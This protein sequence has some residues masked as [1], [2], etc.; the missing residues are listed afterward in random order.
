MSSMKRFFLILAVFLAS[1]ADDEG[2]LD[3][4][5][6]TYDFGENEQSWIPGFTDYSIPETP[7]AE[8]VYDWKYYYGDTAK[9]ANGQKVIML[10]CNNVN[11]DVFMFLKKR[12]DGLRPNTN[13]NLVFDISIA[14]NALAGEGV[15]LKVGGSDLEPKKVIEN[16]YYSLNLD[17]GSSLNSGESLV[18]LG[19]IGQNPTSDSYEY[20]IRNN[21]AT[22]YPLIVKTNSKGELWL[23]VG[24]DSLLEG[25]NA[26][27]YSKI[28]VVFSVSQ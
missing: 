3:I 27:F 16:N 18:S 24:T 7:E 25:Y 26:V 5:S 11:S 17:K 15:I 4:F 20:Q 6:M 9:A 1:C 21:A 28:N 23:I 22:L 12:V 10:S 19:D 8:A 14:T 13:Y 2:Q